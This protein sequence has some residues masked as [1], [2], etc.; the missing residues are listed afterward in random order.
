MVCPKDRDRDHETNDEHLVTVNWNEYPVCRPSTTL[1][2]VSYNTD[3]PVWSFDGPRHMSEH[4]YG[5]QH[6]VFEGVQFDNGFDNGEPLFGLCA[7]GSQTVIGGETDAR[8]EAMSDV[9]KNHGNQEERT[10]FHKLAIV[11]N[12]ICNEAAT[13]GIFANDHG[14]VFT[15]STINWALGLSQD[16]GSTLQPTWSSKLSY[17]MFATL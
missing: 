15:A 17:S 12:G 9:C 7:N 10:N 6:W 4:Q 5:A 13:I 11:R 14:T 1:T 16:P 3:P 8:H 2:G